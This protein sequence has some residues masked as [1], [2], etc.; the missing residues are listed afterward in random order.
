MNSLNHLL[1]VLLLYNDSI[2]FFQLEV[3][4]FVEYY[5]YNM[6]SYFDKLIDSKCMLM[7]DMV[8]RSDPKMLINYKL[9]NKNKKIFNF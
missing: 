4:P 9:K 7:Q 2:S 8:T 5:I 6:V 3:Y 1:E